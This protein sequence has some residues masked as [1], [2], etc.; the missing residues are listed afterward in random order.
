MKMRKKI[1]LYIVSLVALSLVLNFP[2]KTRQ[3]VNGV[4]ETK[5]I[6]LYAKA[7]GY[8][9]RDYQYKSLSGDIVKGVK[10][11][12]ERVMAIYNWTV[13][14]IK[15]SPKGFQIVDDHIWDII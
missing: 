6:A 2:L 14:N 3:G 12:V 5:K 9:Y 15:K 13:N 10:G 11:D 8:L 4:V 1:S 7:C